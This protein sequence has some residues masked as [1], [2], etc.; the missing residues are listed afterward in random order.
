[1]RRLIPITLFILI[2]AI[3]PAIAQVANFEELYGIDAGIRET[4]TLDV[5]W[6]PDDTQI[7]T[8]DLGG[9]VFIW[10]AATGTQ[11][12]QIT[13]EDAP[14]ESVSWSPNGDV[15]ATT[16][17]EGAVTIYDA[18]TYETVVQFREHTDWVLTSAFSPDGRLLTSGGDDGTIHVWDIEAQ[19]RIWTLEDHADEVNGLVWSP[20]GSR[21]A[22]IGTAEPIIIWDT[23]PDSATYGEKIDE[24]SGPEFS[25]WSVDWSPDGERLVSGNINSQVQVWDVATGEEV[26]T[27]EAHANWTS[28]AEFSPDGSLIASGSFDSTLIVWDSQTGEVLT[29]LT[30]HT[31]QINNL[32]WSNDGTRIAT[33]SNDGF[34]RVWGDPNATISAPLPAAPVSNAPAISLIDDT[35][36][37]A[38]ENT[39]QFSESNGN[40]MD[41]QGDLVVVSDDAD[42][43]VLDEADLTPVTTVTGVLL[44]AT[45]IDIS[46]DQSKIAGGY[47]NG[48]NEVYDIATGALDIAVVRNEADV[49]AIVWS[50]DGTQIASADVDGIIYIWDIETGD[51]IN[52]LSTADIPLEGGGE[53][54]PI[55]AI[56]WSPLNDLIVS[57]HNE[58]ALVWEASTGAFVR[59]YLSSPILDLEW[60]PNS[61]R[62][63]TGTVI[64]SACSFKIS[65]PTASHCFTNNNS[66]VNAVTWSVDGRYVLAATDDGTLRLFGSEFP[67]LLDEIETDLG[68]M[69]DLEWGN[70]NIYTFSAG[71]Q[72]TLWSLDDG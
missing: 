21:L 46:P 2:L 10:D 5:D 8:T 42:F 31:D 18:N 50:P 51:I 35:N 49:T 64:G 41:Q 48:T 39:V 28:D 3:Q 15:I 52:R 9:G 38:V 70:N 58:Y 53:L 40:T 13:E 56:D 23:D 16:N 4:S 19:E 57:A 25:G 67:R 55:T 6:S 66:P 26:L 14:I 61:D 65:E 29:Q 62:F 71:N 60:A 72:L 36:L 1:M 69:I 30:G 63:V 17:W 37:S 43:I 47:S 32:D 27:L 22:S 59:A 12:A 7:V 33:V 24:M 34:L 54:G 11:I 20:D 44:T 68:S 45:S